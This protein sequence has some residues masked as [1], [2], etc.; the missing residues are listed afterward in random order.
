[1][2]SDKKSPKADEGK[3]KPF[4][5]Y[6]RKPG[7]ETKG[8]LPMLRFGKGNNFYK[9]KAQL[10]NVAIEKYRYLGKLIE[11]E[12]YNA[13]ALVIPDFRAMGVSAANVG[14]MELEA[15]KGHTKRLEKMV[16][17]RPKLYGLIMQHMSVESRDEV[18]QD[19]DY[20]TWHAEKD[21]EKLWKAIVKTHKVDC[22][23]NVTAVQE[24]TARKA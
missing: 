6:G 2:A 9:F 8:G 23:S 14:T 12:K 4:R 7:E 5:P 13:P 10:S 16:E 1:M 22:V 19:P 15:V 20:V 17:D 24:L 18:A 21:P 11:L 3:K